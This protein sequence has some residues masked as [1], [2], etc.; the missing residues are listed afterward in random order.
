MATAVM[1]EEVLDKAR[2]LN[3]VDQLRLVEALAATLREQR[4]A[5]EQPQSAQE[6]AE[7][8]K[9]TR[10]IMELRGLGKELWRSIDSTEYLRQE[11]DSWD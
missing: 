9:K 11:R 10:S 7:A 8:P 2:Q 6:Q 4:A 1:Y 5:A 3:P